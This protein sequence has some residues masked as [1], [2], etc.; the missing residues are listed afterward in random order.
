MGV[1]MD[2]TT[3]LRLIVPDTGIKFAARIRPRVGKKDA[4]ILYPVGD[5]DDLK[6]KLLELDASYPTENVYY[7]MA[8]YKEAQFKTVKTKDGKDFEFAT[9][10]TQENAKHLQATWFD[11]DVGKLDE[12]GNV[13]EDCYTTQREAAAALANY[14]EKTGVPTPLVITSGYGL[15]CYWPFTDHI[16][17]AEWKALVKLQ[18][19]AWQHLG[20]KVDAACDQDYA[21]VLRA[22]GTHNKKPGKEP[23]LVRVLKEQAAILPAMELKRILSGYVGRNNLTIQTKD[24]TPEWAKGTGNLGGLTEM[25]FPDSYAAIAV[26]HCQQMQDFQ[27][28]GGSSEPVWWANIGLFK[29]FKDGSTYAHQWGAKHD[30]YS[31]EE[32][33][34]KLEQWGAGPTTCEKFKALNPSMCDGCKKTCKSPVQL[35]LDETVVAPNLKEIAE[36]AAAVSESAVLAAAVDSG[37]SDDGL[38]LGWP[39]RYGYDKAHNQVTVKVKDAE[40]V[41]QQVPIANCLFYPVEQSVGKTVLTF[42]KCTCGFAGRFGSLS[43]QPS[44]PLTRGV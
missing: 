42:S 5:H 41:W 8:S 20:M 2:I 7:A 37:F 24:D 11:M 4:T 25:E 13:R 30:D 40:G 26:N 9:G 18:R 31:E 3:F 19:A 36:E 12:D 23:K 44:T 16:E 22:P 38:P 43:C 35:G 33:D 32:T 10:R 39:E 14:C 17:V 1:L 28:T 6:D 29:H 21:R 27:A 15:H 34:Q